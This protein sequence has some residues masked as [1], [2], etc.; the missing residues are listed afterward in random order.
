MRKT[1]IS[2]RKPNERSSTINDANLTEDICNKDKLNSHLDFLT[3]LLQTIPLPVFYKDVFGRYIGC[4]RAFEEFIGKSR[5]EIIGKTVYDMGPGDIAQRYEA[6]DKELFGLPGKQTYEWKVRNSDGSERNVIFHKAAFDD[7]SGKT[8]G[9]IGVILD[10]TDFK[11]AIDA[12]KE[13]ERDVKAILNASTESVL[14]IDTSGIVLAANEAVAH[15]LGTDVETLKGK[16]VYDLISPDVAQI[17]RKEVD[18]VIERGEPVH[19]EDVRGGRDMLNS[20]YPVFNSKKEVKRLAIFGIDIT[21]IM[22]AEDSLRKSEQFYRTT[23]ETALDGYLHIGIDGI[24]RGVNEAYCKL[25]GYTRD[26]LLGMQISDLDA[27]ES[28]EQ[29]AAHIQKIIRNGS[30]LFE[31]KHR[32]KDGS[33]WNVEVSTTYSQ[34]AVPGFSC[35]FRDITQ[36]KR[37]EERELHLK[38]V[39]LAIRNV[40]QL[41]FRE[42][43]PRRLIEKACANLTETLGYFNAWIALLDEKGS[44]TATAASWYDGGFTEM[45]KRLESGRFPECMISAL[46]REEIVII[47]DPSNNCQDCPLSGNYPKR[48]GLAYRL[49][50]EGNIYGVMA[51]SIPYYFAHDKEEQ[52]LFTEIADDLGFAIHKINTA[53]AL[54]ESEQNYRTLADTGQALIWTSGTDKLCNYFNLP[55]LQFTGRS[56]E[57]ELGNGWLEGVHPDD[58]DKAGRTYSDAF[59]KHERFTM[60]YRLLRHDDEYRW[61]LDDG[62]PRYDSIGKFIGYIGHCLDITERKLAEDE[63][64]IT[65]K[66]LSL[67]NASNDMHGLISSVTELLQDWSGCKA[68]GIRLKDGDD[69]PY[70]HTQG[71]PAVFVEA[72]R[73]LCSRDLDGQLLRDEDGNPVLECMCGN[74]I[75]ERF[76]PQLPFFTEHG[77]FWTNSTSELLASTSESDRQARTRNRCNGEGYE[78]VALIP[79]RA[80]GVTFGLMQLNDSRK[81]LFTEENIAL[82]ERLGDSI[83]IALAQRQAQKEL[84]KSEGRTQSILKAVP[85]GIGVVVNRIFTEVNLQVCEM[86]GY[87]RGELIG[88]LSRMLYPTQEDFDYVGREK[89]RQIAENGAGTVE[90]RWIRKDGT[91]IDVLLSSAPIDACDLSKG[92]TFTAF[93]ITEQKKAEKKLAKEATR[94]RILI[95]QSSDGIVVLD[96]NG[97]VY[98]TNQSYA[99]MLGYSM[100]EVLQL[101]VWDWDTQWTREELLDIISKADES[102]DHFET[103]QRRK[104]GTLLDVEIS[105]NWAICNGE[106]LVFCVCR[107]VS[108]RKYMEEELRKSEEKYRELVQNANSI[109]L[110]WNRNGEVLFLNEFGQ[111]FFGYSEA[112]IIG[113][114]VMGTIVPEQEASGRNLSAL[115]DETFEYPEKHARNIN[116]N[117]C[118]DGRRVWISWSNNPIYDSEGLVTGMFSVGT[119]IT[120]QKLAEEALQRSEEKHR[121]MFETM[122]QGVVYQAAD[123]SIISANPAA[124]RILG[125]SLNQMMGKTSM[126]PAWKTILEDGSQLPGTDHPAMVALKTGNPT[127]PI[128]MGVFQPE[129]NAHS[130]LSVSAVPI[131]KPGETTPFQVYATI[132]D[133]TEKRKVEQEYQTLFREMLNGFALHEIICDDQGLPVDY[134]FLAVNPAFERMT[135]LKAEDIV[136]RTVVEVLPGIESYWIETYGCV[137]LTGE[138]FFF[139]NH[140]H[141]L[142]KHFEVTAFQPALNQFACIFSDVTDQKQAEVELKQREKLLSKIFEILPIGLWFA[143]NKGR[144]LKGNP[145]GVKIWGAEPHV[146]IVEYGV[147]KARRLPSGE[148]LA[149]DDWALAHTINEGVTIE[150]ELLEI[151]A[152]DGKKKTILNYTAPVLDDNGDLMGAIVVNNDITELKNTEK[153]LKDSE[154]L[155]KTLF[156]QAAVGVCQVATNGR[157][158]KVNK[159]LSEIVG[160]SDSELIT[161]NFRDITH[162]EDLHLDDEYISMVFAGEINSFEV[163]KRFIHKNGNEIWT[164]LYS[165]VIKDENG[166][167]LYAI[168][169][170]AD[171]TEQKKYEEAIKESEERL[172]LSMEAS[173]YGFWDIDLDTGKMYMSPQIYAMNGYEDGELP[174]N[175]ESIMNLA[176]PDDIEAVMSTFNKSI[177]DIEPFHVDFRV[178]HKSGEWIWISGKGKPVEIDENGKPHRLIGTQVNITPRVKAEESLLY[179]KVAAEEA[180]R[181]KGE[182]LN[183]VSHE[184]RTPLSA[185]LGFSDLLLSDEVEIL[186]ASHREYVGHI[187]HSGKNLLSMVERIL[188]Y[189]NAKYGSMNSLELQSVNVSELVLETVHILSKRAIDKNIK[190]NT[191]P[192]PDLKTIVVDRQK[193]HKILFNLLENAIKFTYPNGFVKIEVKKINDSVQFSVQDTGIGIEREKIET[194][195]EPFVQID[196]SI[197]RRYGGTGLGLALVKKFVEMHNGRIRVESEIG[198]GSAF[199]FELPLNMR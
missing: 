187:H 164:R 104:D 109:I 177:L 54:I 139:E 95:E 44:V 191:S 49:Q 156:E 149:P 193:L 110:K 100:E 61:I 24:I 106:K 79:L 58:I 118:K 89:Y 188:D 145:A 197:S 133:I 176:H 185:V 37:A 75:C 41:I 152:F 127:G 182:L 6:M 87:S 43:D 151:D 142:D 23:I 46:G 181:M 82:F 45:L 120:A 11:Q 4:N 98:E 70:Y 96:E 102:G 146:A 130:W 32:A 160:Y 190:I 20:I 137:A 158:L 150:N 173:Q 3:T 19:F 105:T 195:F 154:Q 38:N 129:K 88:S 168:G 199:I 141:G 34:S 73:Y 128:V 81:G 119:D 131:F 122:N 194:L 121:R 66:L 148:E 174:E 167:I 125:L 8:A 144:L 77:S 30:G 114:T 86:T 92:V 178:K 117:I 5:E 97:K 162:P 16:N 35:F 99:D 184:F 74:I 101:H 69:Y 91:I 180:N 153:A 134:R 163:E 192:A 39:L 90:T 42:N 21:A 83:A 14:L 166:S 52:E 48:S 25:S 80:N 78:S 183:N 157:F 113:K 171:I 126:D 136:G 26:E 124:E 12:L 53:R 159:R 94:R 107:D 62:S 31:T 93:D 103:R 57:Q 63:R 169:V 111:H 115:M 2:P 71:F 7:S 17:R 143:D 56:L 10:I 68:V 64:E 59:D 112:E 138:P 15:R 196:G 165:K 198:R 147:F 13:S 179:A 186:S 123:G 65:I 84:K 76:S 135:G 140:S 132:D 22:R 175:L 172:S 67:L 9:L 85:T 27:I 50:F 189:S 33:I 161:K 55:W 18:K 108:E 155:F 40:N 28:P 60:E 47:T 72:E 116:E 36:H 51:V 1:P 29:T 170:I